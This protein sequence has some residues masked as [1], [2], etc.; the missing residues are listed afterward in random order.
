MA[1]LRWIFSGLLILALAVVV[2]P[3]QANAYNI[4]ATLTADNDFIL[5]TGNA[6]GTVLQQWGTGNDWSRLT[7]LILMT[8]DRTCTSWPGTT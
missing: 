4:T 5:Y 6:T 3:F 2:A 8:T 1:S 7:P